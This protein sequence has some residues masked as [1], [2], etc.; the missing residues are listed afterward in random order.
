MKKL[1]GILVLGLLWCN[2]SYAIGYKIKLL[3]KNEYGI[4]F[5]MTIPWSDDPFI[6]KRLTTML[7]GTYIRTI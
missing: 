2:T 3:E 7:L 6:F 4:V 1:L 5:K